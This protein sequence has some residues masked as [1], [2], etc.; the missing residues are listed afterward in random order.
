MGT[1]GADSGTLRRG[2]EG[3]VPGIQICATAA[4]TT[5][6]VSYDSNARLEPF[7]APTSADTATVTYLKV[8]IRHPCVP[9][10]EV[11][12]RLACTFLCASANI[13]K[14]RGSSAFAHDLSSS[15]PSEFLCSS[16]N[17]AETRPNAHG[18]SGILCVRSFSSGQEQQH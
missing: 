11:T 8:A 13:C 5:T 15:S 10:F 6:S 9:N 12:I 2:A 4:A 17:G 14:H 16:S 18:I 1:A 7:Q 3:A